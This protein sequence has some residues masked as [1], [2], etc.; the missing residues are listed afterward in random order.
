MG[1]G[2]GRGVAAGR[3]APPQGA[4][5]PVGGRR[6]IVAVA[7]VAAIVVAALA[8]SLASGGGTGSA[9]SGD[10]YLTSCAV[11]G[12]GGF[13]FRVLSSS[14]G[15]ALL[16][17]N[18]TAVDVLGCDSQNQVV[19]IDSFSASPGGGGWL[20]PDFPA[21]ATAAGDL[22]F[23]ITYQG[24]AYHFAAS[25]PP[26]GTDCVTFE[27]PSGGTTSTTVANGSGSYCS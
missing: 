11:S 15:A 27:V 21:Q 13:E 12:V 19:H 22:A 8:Y 24:Q 26:V 18:I 23:T 20:V 7:V 4:H 10:T 2:R 25:I 3:A 9:P 14:T 16:G 6:P 1:P 5:G 17:V